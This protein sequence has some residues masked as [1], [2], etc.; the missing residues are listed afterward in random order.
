MILRCL[1][2]YVIV[3]V[4]LRIC[5]HPASKSL[6][7]RNNSARTGRAHYPARQPRSTDR[8]VK[9][10]ACIAMES[11]RMSGE[12]DATAAIVRVEKKRQCREASSLQIGRAHV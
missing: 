4:D 6:I 2:H 9:A 5:I 10:E 8:W 3:N 12:V 11:P 7:W 1:K